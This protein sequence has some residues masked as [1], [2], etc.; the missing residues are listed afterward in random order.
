MQSKLNLRFRGHIK[1]TSN[2]LGILYNNSNT[3][4]ADALEIVTRCLGQL[5]NTQQVDTIIVDGNFGTSERT[6]IENSYNAVD[7]SITFSAI[8]YEGDFDGQISD[9]KLISESLGD[10]V[11]ATKAGL[12]ITKDGSSR[13]RI[14]WKINV[15]QC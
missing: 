4:G 6:V 12:S 15:E 5:G 13:L 2:K 14:D 9:M 3:I 1:A 8:F 11:M 10:K 7:N